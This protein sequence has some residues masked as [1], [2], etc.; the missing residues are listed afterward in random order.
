MNSISF[1]QGLVESLAC[2]ESINGTFDGIISSRAS[3]YCTE[4][5]RRRDIFKELFSLLRPGGWSINADNVGAASYILG[6]LH[7]NG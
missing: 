3:H 2:L 1:I 4:H 5:E 6:D 7:L